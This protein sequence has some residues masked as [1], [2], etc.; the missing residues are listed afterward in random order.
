MPIPQPFGDDTVN[1]AFDTLRSGK[2]AIIFANTKNSAEKTA[3]EIAKKLKEITHETLAQEALNALSSPT[4]QCRRLYECLRKG[5]AFH[6]SGLAP[7]QRELIED[8]FRAR[9][10]SLIAATPT[11]AAGLDLP[12]FRVILKDLRRYGMRGLQYIPVLE[13]LQMAGRAGRPKFDAKGEAILIASSEGQSDELI[14]RYIHGKPEQIYSKLGAEPA[15]R[16]YVLSLV[17]TNVVRTR[18]Q[19]QEFFSK[20]FFAHQYGDTSVLSRKI[21]DTL[22]QLEEWEFLAGERADDFR[23]AHDLMKGAYDATPMGKRVAELYI[24]PY[25][26]HFFVEMLRRAADRVPQAFAWLQIISSTLEMRPRLRAGTRDQELLQQALLDFGDELLEKEPSIYEDEHQEF[27]DSV[28]TALFF[29]DWTEERTE[30]ALLDAYSIRPGETRVKLAIAEWLLYCLEEIS[31]ILQFKHLLSPLRRIKL[32][33]I[34][35][36]KEELLPLLQL[37]HIGRVR[38]R[39]LFNNKIKDLKAVKEADISLLAQLVGATVAADVKRQLGQNIEPVKENK[40]KGQISLQD[41]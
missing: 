14:Q 12:A 5:I 6:H 32:C 30:E 16:T 41:Y 11:L 3:E 31:R 39:K 9:K 26:A 37:R 2:Q 19:I 33:V 15:L 7:K 17:A 23:S 21:D 27:L 25:T 1:L 4:K 40:R 36:V 28:K 8:S 24:D 13:Y 34:N 29:R 35:G 20:T 38:A 10:L 18:K 22:A